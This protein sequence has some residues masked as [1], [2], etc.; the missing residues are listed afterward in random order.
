M[1]QYSG[2]FKGSKVFIPLYFK[3]FLQI[4]RYIQKIRNYKNK[5]VLAGSSSRMRSMMS[6]TDLSVCASMAP[7]SPWSSRFTDSLNKYSGYVDSIGEALDLGV[8]S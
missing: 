3:V 8:G 2:K 4:N 6:E 5:T 1:N 7:D